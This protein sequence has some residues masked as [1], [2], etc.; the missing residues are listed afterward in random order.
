MARAAAQPARSILSNKNAWTSVI[1]TFT[2][3]SAPALPHP[4]GQARAVLLLRAL[5][6]AN[7]MSFILTTTSGDVLT[8]FKKSFYTSPH[9]DENNPDAPGC[10]GSD[11]PSCDVDPLQQSCVELC[12]QDP[13]LPFCG[14]S[15]GSGATPPAGPAPAKDV[16]R[17]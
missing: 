9:C 8:T 5:V 3:R 17:Q 4:R 13:E 14:G 6:A 12:K 2:C 7:S 1:E 15:S 10:D 11:A 16:R